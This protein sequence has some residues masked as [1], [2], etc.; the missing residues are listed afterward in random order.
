MR[1]FIV[2]LLLIWSLPSH[3][4]RLALVIGNADFERSQDLPQ[5]AADAQAMAA[6]LQALDFR[7]IGDQAH[8]D[9]SRAD[10]LRQIR[11]LGR[12][13]R[14]GDEIV[15]YF[16]GHGIGGAQTNYLLP[17][18]DGEIETREDVPDL[19]VDVGSVLDRLSENSE[20]VNIFILD[21]CR[22][23]PLPSRAKSAFA[24]KGLTRVASGASNAVFL[25]AAQPGERAYVS[26]GGRSYFTD[27]LLDALDVPGDDLTNLMRR[28][29]SQVVAKTSAEAVPQNPWIEG[30]TA[31]PFYFRQGQAQIEEATA[32][33]RAQSDGSVPALLEY[34]SEFPDGANSETAKTLITM[35]SGFVTETVS[36]RASVDSGTFSVAAPRPD[37]HWEQYAGL[38]IP[39]CD[40]DA[41]AG[42]DDESVSCHISKVA[43][44]PDGALVAAVTSDGL[45]RVFDQITGRQ[46]SSWSTGYEIQA[47]DIA[48]GPGSKLIVV[49]SPWSDF[50]RVFD[51]RTSY[52]TAVVELKG[53][54]PLRWETTS[55][56]IIVAH[57]TGISALHLEQDTLLITPMLGNEHSI[58]DVRDIAVDGDLILVAGE[59][60]GQPKIAVAQIGAAASVSQLE[61][62]SAR[63]SSFASQHVASVDI[64]PDRGSAVAGTY[65]GWMYVFDLGTRAI[66]QTLIEGEKSAE[67]FSSAI[68]AV[69]W[70]PDGQRILVTDEDPRVRLYDAQSGV[71]IATL[72]SNQFNT[73][74]AT[75]SPAGDKI[76]VA[77][78]DG[79][80]RLWRL[81]ERPIP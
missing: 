74:A 12:E 60:S 11:T 20:G 48:W 45:I 51:A 35:K 5:T 44:S 57:E 22:D 40:T 67:D 30:L 62:P 32:W 6:K 2:L 14:D 13:A 31:R 21:A 29:R 28:V 56:R 23:N 10:M 47:T 26:E 16:S 73:N 50:V 34:L 25:Y 81:I 38:V 76:A 7:L 18:D 9:L 43:W 63:A 39:G 46:V 4:D 42:A 37:E 79:T 80:L 55:D 78:I 53:A 70:S 64:S 36:S 3:A 49:T 24:Q 54:G 66:R 1:C 61:F 77:S 65:D 33:Q 17:V 69:G 58:D 27:A 68:N 19:A 15:F 72:E 52:E 75:F 8:I 71:Q 59:T 41:D